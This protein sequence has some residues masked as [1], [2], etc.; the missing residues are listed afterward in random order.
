MPKITY[1]LNG[2]EFEDFDMQFV[3]L[4]EMRDVLDVPHKKGYEFDGFYTDQALTIK[5]DEKSDITRDITLYAKW[6]KFYTITFD[7][8]G[9]KAVGNL[10]VSDGDTRIELPKQVE[11]VGYIFKG[12]RIVGTDTIVNDVFTIESGVH[13]DYTF[14]AV[15][16]E[17]YVVNIYCLGYD[18]NSNIRF[19][20]VK[21]IT[22]SHSLK[23]D[24][25]FE[26]FYK[27]LGQMYK[28]LTTF[29]GIYIDE[30]LTT[31]L[32]SYP[33]DNMNLYFKD[34][35]TMYSTK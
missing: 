27:N 10:F 29:D 15:Y 17:G 11:K 20:L 4:E 33:L 6:N 7:T 28:G 8:V 13:K 24:Y 5:Y 22:I 23:E 31:L 14:E 21:T 19:N 32:S 25:T 3:T 12:W 9:G 2:G 26:E 35:V 16:Y 18:S 34:K 1:E 30:T